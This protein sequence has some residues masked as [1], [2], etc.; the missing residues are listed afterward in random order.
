MLKLFVGTSGYSY[1]EWRGSFYPAK[2]PA[3]GMLRYYGERFP[4]VEINHT[5][6]RMP[7]P[8]TLQQW[9]GEVPS[10]FRFAVKAPGRITHEARLVG[11]EDPLSHFLKVCSVLGA[12]LGPI[13]FQLPPGMKR[14]LGLL[15]RFL[16]LLPERGRFAWEFRHPSWDDPE[17]LSVLSERG[18]ALCLAD[19]DDVPLGS[20]R[21]GQT[22]S[23]GYIRLRRAFYTEEDLHGWLQSIRSQPWDE[24]YVFFKHEQA[25][26]GA[27]LAS[28]LLR[29]S[30]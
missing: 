10:G 29:M 14:D 27:E 13:L 12:N 23:W 17:V 25:G 16:A 7:T 20:V 4:T 24:A 1:P 3:R 30:R 5:F 28:Q 22:V 6:Y 11:V 15:R 21:W 18:V 19:T 9:A 26:V 2:V 8:R